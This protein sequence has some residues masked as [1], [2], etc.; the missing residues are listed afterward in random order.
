MNKKKSNLRD[1]VIEVE[2]HALELI[3]DGPGANIFTTYSATRPMGAYSRDI[4][5]R[6]NDGDTPLQSLVNAIIR[7]TGVSAHNMQPYLYIT[8]SPEHR[9]CAS[10]YRRPLSIDEMRYIYRELDRYRCTAE[11]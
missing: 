1:D 2:I 7:E 5:A 3:R 4:N 11:F 6:A 8:T 10:N 9:V